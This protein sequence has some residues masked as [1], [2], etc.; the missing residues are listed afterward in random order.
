[1]AAARPHSVVSSRA[2][3]T[4]LITLNDT[5]FDNDSKHDRPPD[6]EDYI[7]LIDP[8]TISRKRARSLCNSFNGLTPRAKKSTHLHSGTHCEAELKVSNP[9]MEQAG[10]PQVI[11]AL[12]MPGTKKRRRSAAL[13]IETPLRRSTRIA[14]A[15]DITSD[16]IT[17]S[18][19]SLDLDF[20]NNSFIDTSN[21]STASCGMTLINSQGDSAD[22]MSQNSSAAA[23]YATA[24]TGHA[25]ISLN[26][27]SLQTPAFLRS[28]SVLDTHSLYVST[29]SCG[30]T[31]INPQEE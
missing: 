8:R 10:P 30:M 21:V 18:N 28:S 3:R 13:P 26:P 29:A 9:V 1:M 19:I 2:N 20:L 14:A 31:L 23:S 5:S 4:N 12:Q 11:M 15:H 27:S 16:L 6:G 17:P 24:S 22:N 25:E 7:V